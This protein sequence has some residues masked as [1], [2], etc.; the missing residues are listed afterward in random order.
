[1][2]VVTQ[3]SGQTRLSPKENPGTLPGALQAQV[4]RSFLEMVV[5]PG[6][7]SI[8]VFL[9]EFDFIVITGDLATTGHVESAF[10]P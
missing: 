3:N 4:S 9:R 10:A 7:G 5:E 8:I 2:S 6:A 1:M